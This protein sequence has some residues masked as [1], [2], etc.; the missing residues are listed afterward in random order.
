VKD[1]EIGEEDEPHTINVE[2]IAEKCSGD[3][4][5]YESVLE[6]LETVAAMLDQYS[7]TEREKATVEKRLKDLAKRL[8]NHEKTA[9]WK[10]RS[11]VG[12]HIQWCQSVEEE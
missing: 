12:K 9:K 1:S 8:I 2:Y 10:V 5:L 3:W 6:N 11:A 7:L 4:G